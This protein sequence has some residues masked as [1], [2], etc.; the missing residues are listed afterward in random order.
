MNGK[1]HRKSSKSAMCKVCQC[2]IFTDIVTNSYFRGQDRLGIS[3]SFFMP[4]RNKAS[5]HGVIRSS[6]I[7]IFFALEKLFILWFLWRHIA[8]AK[9]NTCFCMREEAKTKTRYQSCCNHIPGRKGNAGTGG[10]LELDINHTAVVV[11]FSTFPLDFAGHCSL[12][13][14]WDSQRKTSRWSANCATW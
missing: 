6:Y 10:K 5:E 4:F 8:V 1:C 11:S 9:K 12:R 3:E 13:H 7:L 2:A 14:C